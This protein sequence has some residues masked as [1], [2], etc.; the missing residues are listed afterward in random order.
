VN[1]FVACISRRVLWLLCFVWSE[2][3]LQQDL[4]LTERSLQLSFNLLTDRIWPAK[5]RLTGG[6][7]D[8]GRSV[9][10]LS[11][12]PCPYYSTSQRYTDHHQVHPYRQGS[13]PTCTPWT[14]AS[15]VITKALMADGWFPLEP[16]DSPSATPYDPDVPL[17]MIFCQQHA[18][19]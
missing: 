12:S 4:S 7:Q 8:N 16:S 17:L 18:G 15:P 3:L 14:G 19:R 5:F 1:T 2:L 9:D 10:G 11:G 6:H 13:S